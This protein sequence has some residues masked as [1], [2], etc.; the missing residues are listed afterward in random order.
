MEPGALAHVV[1]LLVPA[2][3]TAWLA[4]RVAYRWFDGLW[5]LFPPLG[6]A[7]LVQSV[8]RAT[9]LP[10]RNWPPRPEEVQRL[11]PIDSVTVA[12]RAVY[13]LASQRPGGEA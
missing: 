6:L 5:W 12:G 1:G 2:S 8:W 7:L 4:P 3:V 11:R 10:Y 9:L 13:L